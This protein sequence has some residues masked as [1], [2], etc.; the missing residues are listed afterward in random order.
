MSV[1]V[2]VCRGQPVKPI[3]RHHAE[4]R[5]LLTDEP[6]GAVVE[7]QREAAA[8]VTLAAADRDVVMSV[9]IEIR[10][11]ARARVGAPSFALP[12]GRHEPIVHEG[13]AGGVPVGDIE[14]RVFVKRREKRRA[15]PALVA[16]EVCAG[17]AVAVPVGDARHA[18][19][20]AGQTAR[21]EPVHAR[22][23]FRQPVIIR[24]EKFRV[25]LETARGAR[26]A[27]ERC[28]A[29]RIKRAAARRPVRAAS[30]RV[31]VDNRTAERTAAG[32]TDPAARAA[33][34]VVRDGGMFKNTPVVEPDAPAVGR[35][36]VGDDQ[37]VFHLAA[38][39]GEPKPPARRRYV[40]HDPA[41][42]D[43]PADHVG[44]AACCYRRAAR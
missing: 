41:A 21:R 7:E 44:T 1:T 22:R 40:G 17:N 19:E 35:G 2:E 12:P 3:L 34:L 23:G 32:E 5:R 9:L 36:R 25:V 27:R 29:D 18:C 31:A 38:V 33:G 14:L 37:A 4:H 28:G 10:D 42:G 15:F 43:R 30:G 24:H 39:G 11:G 13:V 26:Q 8:L 16:A 6:V 20:I